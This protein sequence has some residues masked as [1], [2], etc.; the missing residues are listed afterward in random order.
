VPERIS[1]HPA[2]TCPACGKT[3]FTSR[4]AARRSAATIAGR[5]GRR[6]MRAYRCLAYRALWHLTSQPKRWRPEIT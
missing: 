3:G 2:V 4:R 6:R 1:E 5:I